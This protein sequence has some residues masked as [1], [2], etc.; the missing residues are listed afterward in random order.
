MMTSPSTLFSQAH[1][2]YLLALTAGFAGLA[3]GLAIKVFRRSTV[4]EVESQF[5]TLAEAIPQIVWTAGPEG[6]TNYIN[7]R[8]YEMTGS[9][10]NSGPGNWVESVHPDDRPT[11][12]EKWQH[13]L[14]TGE[15]LELEYRLR[16]AKGGYCWYLDRA[17]PMRDGSGAIVKW[18]GTCTDIDGQRRTQEL[19]EK[20]VQQRTAAL[21][22]ANA[23]LQQESIRDPLT[24]LYNRRYLE[25]TLERETRRAVRAEGKLGFL[26]LDLDHFK[27]FND[28]YGHAAGDLV[29]RETAA[30]LQKS[31]RAE[32]AVCRFGG[33]E[34]VII[35]PMADLVTTRARAERIRSRLHELSIEHQGQRLGRVTVSVGVAALPDHG[36]S[37]KEL[38][39]SADTALYRAKS[40]G[41]D[42]VVTAPAPVGEVECGNEIA[43]V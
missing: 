27:K 14:R 15:A 21:F 3:A 2:Y 34:F 35:L 1:D 33:E 36:T 28:S 11:C 22:E 8:W 25:E 37:A 32:D 41:R 12:H 17:I 29:L 10:A 42:C 20:Q 24:G 39:Q 30:F 7:R 19:L 26:M 16:D 4:R 38:L 23:R 13:C 5:R 43:V 31:V 18:F 6:K 40:Q 9:P